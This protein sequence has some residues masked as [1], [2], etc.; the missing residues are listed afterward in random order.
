MALP[1]LA[2]ASGRMRVDADVVVASSSGWAHGFPT[3]GRKIVYCHAPARWLYQG[4]R[5]LG[6]DPRRSPRGLALLALRRPLVRW[7]RRAALSADA[8]LANSHVV[9]DRIAD[10]Y[11]ID[12]PV[13][14]PPFAVDARGARSPVPGIEDW[15]GYHLVVSRLLPYKNVD[16]IVEAFSGLPERLVVIGAGPLLETL[17]AS[18]PENVAVVT[19]LTD[20]QMRWAYAHSEALVAASHEDFGLTPLEAGSFGKP[21]LALHAGGYLDTI[22]PGVNGEFFEEPTTLAIQEAV[23]ANRGCDWDRD[24]IMRHIVGFSPE[25]F[26]ARL[27]ADVEELVSP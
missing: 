16:K 5:Y 18:A 21:T 4:E 1:F 19:E 20:D 17:R 14:P 8:Y 11:G 13:L 12:A 9:R 6:A 7:D 3:S 24:A 15:S 27:R 23:I 10:A 2:W 25:R 22:V 26:V